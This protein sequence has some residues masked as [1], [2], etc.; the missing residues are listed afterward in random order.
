MVDDE[1]KDSLRANR[2]PFGKMIVHD[3]E[4]NEINY[5]IEKKGQ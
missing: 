5:L 4:N 3:L 2:A 1:D